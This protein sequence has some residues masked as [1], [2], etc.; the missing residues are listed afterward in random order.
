MLTC[1]LLPELDYGSIPLNIMLNI[2]IISEL[3]SYPKKLI[4]LVI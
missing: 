2:T 1:Y 4:S 3:I